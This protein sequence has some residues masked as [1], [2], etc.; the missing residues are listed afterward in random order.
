MSA[1]KWQDE[2][3]WEIQ[4]RACAITIEPRQPHCDRGNW[5]AKV[6]SFERLKVY[7]DDQDN[8]PRYYFDL[9]RAKLECEAWLKK[10]GQWLTSP[11]ASPPT[12]GPGA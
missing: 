2:S 4:G 10:Q 7:I 8:W 11:T 5:L 9:E 3:Y 6:F 12:P 1:W